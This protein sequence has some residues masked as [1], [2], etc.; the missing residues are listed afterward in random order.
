MLTSP[1]VLRPANPMLRHALI[2][3]SEAWNEQPQVFREVVDAAAVWNVYEYWRMWNREPDETSFRLQIMGFLLVL[4]SFVDPARALVEIGR[5]KKREREHWHMED[6]V[7]QARRECR[8][9]PDAGTLLARKHKGTLRLGPDA[10]AVLCAHELG[11][12]VLTDGLYT[13]FHN[14]GHEWKLAH[15]GLILAGASKAAGVLRKAARWAF[16]NKAPGSQVEAARVWDRLSDDGRKRLQRAGDRFEAVSDR[17]GISV[18]R[19]IA[20]H[21]KEFRVQG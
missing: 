10:M 6:R 3:L 2:V 20:A 17:V 7:R 9:I 4:G 5:L 16:G 14:L 19:Y 1:A 8:G 18:D 13:Y 21:R 12:H 11:E 15:D